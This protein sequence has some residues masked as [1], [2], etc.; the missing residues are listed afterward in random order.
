VNGARADHHNK[1]I[2]HPMQDTMQRLAGLIDQRGHVWR[3]RKLT[4]GMRGWRKL[5]NFPDTQI[6]SIVWHSSLLKQTALNT[7]INNVANGGKKTEQW[8]ST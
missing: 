8:R 7:K 3:A 5:F 2:I 1:A 6:I 4:H